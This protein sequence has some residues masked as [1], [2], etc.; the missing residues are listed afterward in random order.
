MG[1][2]K[3]NDEN[4]HAIWGKTRIEKLKIFGTEFC[5]LTPKKKNGRNFIKNQL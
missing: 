2:T 3:Q 4:P 1:P 5:V